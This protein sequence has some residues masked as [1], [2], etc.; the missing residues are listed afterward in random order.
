MRTCLCAGSCTRGSK[1]TAAGETEDSLSLRKEHGNRKKKVHL[2]R[3]RKTGQ[4]IPLRDLFRGFS[5][6]TQ[7]T[8]GLDTA[9]LLDRKQGPGLLHCRLF[10]SIPSLYPLIPIITLLPSVTVIEKCFQTLP[11]GSWWVK[12]PPDEN[13]WLH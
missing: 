4:V 9:L 11:N 10:I 12:L 7:S 3:M 5:R 13:D 1:F 2:R 8:F 6:A